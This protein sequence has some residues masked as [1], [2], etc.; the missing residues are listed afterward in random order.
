MGLKMVLS[1]FV[2]GSRT[3]SPEYYRPFATP[4]VLTKGELWTEEA[5]RSVNLVAFPTSIAYPNSVT[6][7]NWLSVKAESPGINVAL[8]ADSE[9]QQH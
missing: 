9:V 1:V 7:V 4:S 8:I 5:L 2:R 6:R 3:T